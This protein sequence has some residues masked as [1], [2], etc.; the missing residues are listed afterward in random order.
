MALILLRM[1]CMNVLLAAAVAVTTLVPLNDLG[2]NPYAFGYY[3]G[4]WDVKN[5]GDTT[6]PPD[7]AAA[8]LCSAAKIQPRDRDGNP[9]PNGK[10]GFLA[11]GYGN[12]RKTFEQFEAIA[13]ADP[14]VNHDSL[15]LLNAAFDHID[16]PQWE[17]PWNLIYGGVSNNVLAPAGI[18]EAQ[19]QVVWL[20]QINEHPFIPLP[21]Q[22]ADAYVVK[23]EIANALRALKT[24]YPNLQIAYLS[25]PEYSGY[26][27]DHVLGEPFAY[28]DGLSVRWVILGQ[29]EFMRKGEI[30]DPRIADLS[31][32]EGKAP[33]TTWGPYLWANGA[34]P[35]SDGL[36]WLRS[37]FTSDGFTLSE[38][39]ARKSAGLLM[40]FLLGEPTAAPWFVPAP[41]ST[42]IRRRS[43]R[44]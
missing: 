31:Y 41:A 27:T 18:S 24:W 6:I 28:E 22:Y 30:W 29:I 14:H 12:T 44:R 34:T 1:A 39:G 19:V 40:K 2:P 15:V 7:H 25:S 38:A 20:Q 32:D 21:I 11:V 5:T 42:P 10:I 17:Q 26:D 8:G 23:G 36:T 4:L 3:G 43:A 13:A 33:W 9:D 16:A 37:D 35:R